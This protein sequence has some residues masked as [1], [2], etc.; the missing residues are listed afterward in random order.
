MGP[1]SGPVGRAGIVRRIEAHPLG[2][3]PDAMRRAFRDLV[4]GDAR[5]PAAILSDAG[6]AGGDLSVHE[7][8]DHLAV[9]TGP[10]PRVMWLHGGGYVF[11]GPDTHLRAAAV[12]ARL[13]GGT[14][15]LPRYRLAPEHRW[16]APLED[17]RAAWDRLGATA[18]MGD[19]AGGH[20]ALVLALRLAAEGRAPDRLALL[21]PNA[22]RTG[23]ARNRAAAS[24]LDPMNDDA[25]DRALAADAGLT[26]DRP[27][28]SPALA[29][30]S[31]LPPTWIEVGAP[32]VLLGDSTLL[33]ERAAL[34][35]AACA[36][37]VAPGLLHMGQLWAPW[38]AEG[39]ASLERV[40]AHLAV[41]RR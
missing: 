16:P 34:A 19:S 21:A 4:L 36:L 14:V 20:L 17:A 29:D 26:A 9:A 2:D 33:A 5:A 6:L 41:T 24:P 1:F 7:A 25:D 35:G 31:G 30:L 3:A 13:L 18:L 10:G 32:E 12:L 37:H 27:D 15:V 39:V 28:A 40:A 38:W 23:A 11:G 8:D 22:D